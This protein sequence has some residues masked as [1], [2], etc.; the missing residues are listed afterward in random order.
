M[1][2]IKFGN[3]DF[4]GDKSY[5]W[6]SGQYSAP[7]RSVEVAHVLG[8]NG[9]VILDNGRYENTKATYTV[10]IMGDVP[11]NTDRLKYLLYSQIG[12]QRLYDS[13]RKGFYRKAAFYDGFDIS[14]INH[15]KC[16]IT[17]DCNPYQ[18]D[19]NGD[20]DVTFSSAGNIINPYY[21][22][23]KPK[24]TVSGN[25][26]GY[27]NIGNQTIHILDMNEEITIDSEVQEVY[28]SNME[29]K[30]ASV[31]L[32]DIYLLPGSNSISFTGGVTSVIITP[33]WVTL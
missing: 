24:I 4:S 1:P 13:N 32:S 33:R 31:S 16:K 10:V 14:G 7:K 18:Y 25:G 28:N 3:V 11:K 29:N 2:S 17:F 22:P 8:K 19:I 12:Y 20:I 5:I 6:G 23:S 9:D 30:N 27:V 21:E 26:E 15:G